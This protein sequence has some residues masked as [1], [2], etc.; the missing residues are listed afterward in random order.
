[1]SKQQ[2]FKKGDWI[3]HAFYG[4]GQIRAVETKKL[5]DQSTRYFKVDGRNSTFFVPVNNVES[6][7]IRPLASRQKLRKALKILKEPAEEFEGD[8]NA[9][10]RQIAERVAVFSP[11]ATAELVRDLAG[12]RAA[13]GLN[14]HEERAFEQAAFRLTREWAITEDLDFEEAQQKLEAALDELYAKPAK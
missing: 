11:E 6:A 12:R 13:H 2:A 8:H 14:D 3:V 9:R 7:R 1:M 10:K 5:G 4:V